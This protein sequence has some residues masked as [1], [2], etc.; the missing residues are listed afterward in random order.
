[1]NGND[2]D[3]TVIERRIR[4]AIGINRSRRLV[5]DVGDEAKFA[6]VSS[7]MNDAV[8][9]SKPDDVDVRN[10]TLSE[11]SSHARVADAEGIV[12][13][14]IHLEAGI[15]TLVEDSVETG[16]IELGDESS[17]GRVLYAMWWP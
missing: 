9:S 8:I 14:R 1:M 5:D 7:G 11:V 13:G 15:K 10:V 2:S 17:A 3:A 12:K 4:P 16:P 6:G